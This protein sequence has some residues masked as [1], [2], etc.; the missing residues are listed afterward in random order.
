MDR[1]KDDSARMERNP[2]VVGPVRK[3]G[4]I[5]MRRTQGFG[6]LSSKSPA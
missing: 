6:S 5:L 3:K 2:D 1:F 4:Y